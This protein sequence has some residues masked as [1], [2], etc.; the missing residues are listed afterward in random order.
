MC[1]ADITVDNPNV[2]F[3][4]GYAIA[5]GKEVVFICSE[6]R[7]T[8]FPFDVQHRTITKYATA[9]PRDFKELQKTVTQRLKAMLKSNQ[10]LGAVSKLPPTQKTQGLAPHEVAVL[11]ILMENRLAPESNVAPHQI[12]ERMRR[13]GFRD[14]AVSL[15]L[16]GLHEQGYMEYVTE[17]N[18][19]GE[20]Y[21][22]CSITPKGL[23]WIRDNQGSLVLTDAE[24]IPF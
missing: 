4:V 21:T 19:F 24:D 22:V 15:G 23:K 3:E 10:E 13:L 6:D 12:Q 2:W 20:P 14:I 11:V 5:A 9:S 16:N 8:P 17:S 1:L 7:R 18:N